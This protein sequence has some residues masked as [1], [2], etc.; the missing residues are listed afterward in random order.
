MMTPAD[1]IEHALYTVDETYDRTTEYDTYARQR[2]VNEV[3]DCLR[4]EYDTT[5]INGQRY[6]LLPE[7]SPNLEAVA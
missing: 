7:P 4:S 6:L 1:I 5:T 3:M 2:Q